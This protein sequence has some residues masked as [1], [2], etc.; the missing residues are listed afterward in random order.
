M[1]VRID[2]TVSQKENIVNNYATLKSYLLRRAGRK[3]NDIEYVGL[4]RNNALSDLD[5]PGEALT[6]ILEYIT[7]VDDAGEIALYGTYKPEDFEITRDFVENEITSSFLT[8]LK[9][10]SIAGGIAGATVATNPRIRIQDRVSLIDSFTG[11]GSI[12]NIHKGPTAIFYRTKTGKTKTVGTFRFNNGFDGTTGAVAAGFT[13][14]LA[15][16]VNAGDFDGYKRAFILSSY[17]NPNTNEEISLIGTGIYLE[18][19]PTVS[20]NTFI[21]G[22]E[23]SLARIK[24]LRDI[25]STATFNTLIF[26]LEREYSVLTQPRWFTASPSADLGNSVP[27]AGSPDDN[28]PE[29]TDAIVYFDKG[30]FKLYSEPEYYNSGAYVDDRIALGDRDSYQGNNITKD[31]NMRFI[32]PPRVLR[33]NTYNW[34]VRWDG[35]LRIDRAAT[36]R[37]YIFEVETN[38][39]IKID[40]YNGDVNFTNQTITGADWETVIDTSYSEVQSIDNLANISAVNFAN[41]EDRFISSSSFTLDGIDGGEAFNYDTSLDGTTGIRYVPISIRMWNGG[42]DKA[43]SEQEVIEVPLEPNVF[44]KY[45][46]SET[47]AGTQDVFFSGDVNIGVAANTTDVTVNT[48]GTLLVNA[49][50]TAGSS[51]I[52]QLIQK[53]DTITKEYVDENGDTITETETVLNDINPITVTLSGTSTSDIDI[54]TAVDQADPPNDVKSTLTAGN[55]TLRILPNRSSYSHTTLWSTKIIGPKQLEYQG[56]PDLLGGKTFTG[57]V[58]NYIEPLTNK[59]TLDQRP[60]YWKVSDGNRFIYGEAIEKDNDPLD[61]FR[62]NYFASTL[63]S[64]ESPTGS[65]QGLY[66]DGAGNFSTRKNMLL[67]E[68]RYGTNDVGSNYI[69]MRLTSNYLG[70]GGKLKFTGIPINNAAFDWTGLSGANAALGA[71]DLGGSPNHQ[72][73]VA[74]NLTERN[75]TLHYDGPSTPNTCGSEK[76][77]VHDNLGSNAGSTGPVI[78]QDNPENYGLPAFGGND[79]AVWAQPIIIT[80]TKVDD[81]TNGIRSL[82]APLI[83]SM[84][85]VIY[86]R[87]QTTPASRIITDTTSALTGNQVYLLAF[88]TSFDPALSGSDAIDGQIIYYHNEADVAFQFKNVDT[89]ESISF[90][91]ALKVSYDATPEA[92]TN[93][94]GFNSSASEVPKVPSERVTPFGFDSPIYTQDICYPPYTTSSPPLKPTVIDDA[95]LYA[96]GGSA[97]PAGNYDVIWGNHTETGLS[98]DNF[99]GGNMRLNITEK[100]EFSYPSVTIESPANIIEALSSPPTLTDSDYSHR[101]KIELPIFNVDNP[102]VALDED[103]YYHIGNNEKVKDVYYLFVNGRENT[104]DQTSSVLPGLPT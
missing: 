73:I 77:Y 34:G 22:D 86:D 78:T 74:A 32:E 44:L 39:A 85:K 99:Q 64:A 18:F 103:I 88:T 100:F 56:Y 66:G 91:D 5:D 93:P 8:P 14:T 35:Y 101:L 25:F 90:A 51:C 54:L 70:E 98:G 52:F 68:T 104:A 79:D 55:Y 45:A 38:T 20:P 61:G 81:G 87:S 84:E 92:N 47:N 30:K 36:A 97:Q 40:I 28:N 11:K 71:S 31:S 59:L 48:G 15:A 75:T 95:T 3:L 7:R 24:Q 6:N 37:K 26:N 10:I 69:G 41:E 67:G 49:I 76:F 60:E 23:A 43:D 17:T 94:N 83:M 2:K 96:T 16:G 4:L 21:I 13:F 80:V 29:T 58:P 50:T 72:T 65:Y 42:P 46:Y 63:K 53:E 33:D 102:Q 12:S 89:G 82:A 62:S 1:A 19:D 27:V 9:D 57:S